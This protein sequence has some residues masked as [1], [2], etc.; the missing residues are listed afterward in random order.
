[1]PAT[2]WSRVRRAP[3]FAGRKS[4]EEE[5]VGRQARDDERRQHRGRAGD[6]GHRQP[7]RDRR[8]N[9]PVAR[10]GDERRAG[11][12]DERQRLSLAQ[13]VDHSLAHCLAG[14][15][16][17]GQERRRDAVMGKE[18]LRDPRVLGEH[19]RRRGEHAQRPEGDVAQ[20]ADRRRHDV[21]AGGKRLGLG[22]E[23]EGGEHAGA[24]TRLLAAGAAV[25]FCRSWRRVWH[26]YNPA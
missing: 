18:P 17:V 7:R 11:V 9:E 3:L 5:P 15:V 14:M 16:V 26:G 1:M 19:G 10:V 25:E 21:K 24:R 6:R 12:R 13:A 23:A 20:I 22:R 8:L 4:L 2:A